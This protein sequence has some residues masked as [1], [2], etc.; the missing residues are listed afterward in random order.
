MTEPVMPV[1]LSLFGRDYCGALHVKTSIM[2]LI[3]VLCGTSYFTA[4]TQA[5]P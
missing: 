4:P 1:V 3:D 2:L 5:R